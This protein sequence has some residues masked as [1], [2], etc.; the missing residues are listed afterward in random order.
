MSKPDAESSRPFVACG[1]PVT[2]RQTR[3][4]PETMPLAGLRENDHS[5]LVVVGDVSGKGVKAALLVSVPSGETESEDLAPQ[6]GF[7]LA[8]RPKKVR[9]TKCGPALLP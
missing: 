6:V 8:T 5:L 9:L 3:S 4:I 1:L 7:E 2:V